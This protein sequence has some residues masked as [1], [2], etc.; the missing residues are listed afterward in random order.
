MRLEAIM[1]RL[2]AEDGCPWDREQTHESLKKYAV[3]EVY[4][5][6]DAVDS[7]DREKMVEELGDLL[8]QVVFHA[9]LGKERGDFTLDDVARGICEKLI[10]R[11]PHVF[12]DV[13][14][15][16]AEAVLENWERLKS[17]ESRGQTRERKGLLDG[18][19]DNLP[20]LLMIFRIVEK[21]RLS[22]HRPEWCE[23]GVLRR[24]IAETEPRPEAIGGLIRDL[25]ALGALY[26]IDVEEV[27]RREG[28]KIKEE[29][30]RCSR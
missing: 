17:R 11:H 20:A 1:E 4:E 26:G 15:G 21:I 3:E 25:A 6:L 14:L 5:F 12:G 24:R 23:E 18:V 8:L 30:N 10:R 16:D 28:R 9:Q 2:R 27:V 29:I 19:P 13:D 22:D 7:G